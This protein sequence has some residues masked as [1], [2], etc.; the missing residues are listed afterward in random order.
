LTSYLFACIDNAEVDAHVQVARLLD[1]AN[2]F[3]IDLCKLKMQIILNADLDTASFSGDGQSNA[4]NTIARSFI[5]GIASASQDRRKICT[6]L[7]TVLNKDCAGKIR[8]DVEELFLDWNTFLRTRQLIE[9]L[10]LPLAHDHATGESLARAFLS[11]IEA[12]SASISTAG[13]QFIAS[14]LVE[15]IAKLLLII[16][17]RDDDGSSTLPEFSWRNHDALAEFRCWLVLFLRLVVLHRPAFTQPKSSSSSLE[18]ARML[19]GLCCLLQHDIIR[20]D[21][22]HFELVLGI[23]GT[24]CDGL[25]DDTRLQLKRYS[26]GKRPV[27]M[28]GYLLGATD[29]GENLRALQKG[30]AVEFAVKPWERLA[31]P[32]PSIGE[33][34]VSLSLALFKTRR[35]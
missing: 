17:N 10:D 8:T 24:F 2:D 13:P 6:D 14:T 15:R 23:A 7:V 16:S 1:L 22:A 31:E 25:P 32:T 4:G 27:P 28:G 5:R 19:A 18:Q 20:N 33:N 29:S 21:D 12:T 34:D 9:Q 30:K 3:S 35:F 11:V 26:K